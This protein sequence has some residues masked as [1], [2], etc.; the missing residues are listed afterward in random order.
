V[1]ADLATYLEA[2]DHENAVATVDPAWLAEIAGLRQRWP[3]TAELAAVDGINPNALMHDISAASVRAGAFVIDVGQHQMWAAQSMEV[4][5]GQRFLTSGGMGAM[6]FA[7]PAAIGASF[8]LGDRPVVVVAGD[9]GF[10]L[11]LQE[12]QTVARH[13]LPLKIVVV[14]NGCHGM[15]RQF[16]EQYMEGVYASTYWGYSA[17][18]FD[19]VA[20]AYGIRA[21]RVEKPAELADGLAAMWADPSAPYLLHV[22]VDTFANAYPKMSF[23]L[24]MGEMEPPTAAEQA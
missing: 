9:G 20:R 21:S 6:G 1:V 5:D 18:E 4:R 17:P 14:D 16:Q 13:G 2:L 19:A 10:Q 23:G 3:D 12:L 8:A 24:P 7:L 11:N 22:L 15:V